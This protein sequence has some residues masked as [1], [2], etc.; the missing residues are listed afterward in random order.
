MKKSTGMTALLYCSAIIMSFAGAGSY[1]HADTESPISPIDPCLNCHTEE[2]PKI[3][4]QWEAGK[5]SKTGVKCYVC[6]HTD[7]SNKE[8]VEHNDF[9]VI[10]SVDVKT[11]E[12]CHP[13][14]AGAL[15]A[16]FSKESEMHP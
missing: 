16:Q 12:S 9:F 4:Q 6:H 2:T 14:N 13:E 11:C 10:T 15:L 3:V 1:V 8:G 7:E 5:H